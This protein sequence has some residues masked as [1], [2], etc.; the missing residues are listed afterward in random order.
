MLPLRRDARYLTFNYTDT[1]QRV[2]GVPDTNVLH[3]HGAA[4]H[5]DDQ[6]ILGHG[7]KRSPVDS[8][9]HGIDHEEA[10]TRVME[11]NNIIDGY[12]SATFKRTDR[13]ITQHQPFFR[14]LSDIRTVLVMGHSLSEV[15]MP[16]LRE[17]LN[18]IGTNETRWQV[19]FYDS[20]Q[21]A[22]DAM[23]DLGVPIDETKYVPL[24]TLS[25]WAP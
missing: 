5:V 13:V 22:E 9:N 6:L 2:Y 11:G 8:F 14:S 23:R 3:I 15:D 7:W 25:L 21:D 18:H 1:L 10:D 12:F 17:V 4:K 24:T 16:Y 19:S 20:S